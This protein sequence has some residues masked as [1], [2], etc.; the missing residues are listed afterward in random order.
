M[1]SWPSDP[2]VARLLPD[3]N[4]DDPELAAGYRRL[5]EHGLRTRKRAALGAAVA[6]LTRDDPVFLD[7]GE[8]QALA[9]GLNDVRLVLASRLGVRT[10][11]DAERLHEV[12]VQADGHQDPAVAAAAVYEALTWWQDSLIS[13]LGRGPGVPGRKVA[14]PE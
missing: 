3:G 14:D 5:T 12:L 6:A 13:T 8:A 2:A 11:E 1:I 7:Q 10:D 9:K 4:R